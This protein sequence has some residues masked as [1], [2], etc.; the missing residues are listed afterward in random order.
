M[1]PSEGKV[2][3]DVG[4]R[5]GQTPLS[6]AA[7]RGYTAVIKLLLDTGKVNVDLKAEHER[8][9]LLLAAEGWHTVVVKLLLDSKKGQRGFRKYVWINATIISRRA[10]IRGSG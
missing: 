7:Q 10:W 5:Y 4:D 9:P 8:T 1:L 3:S 6:L 2:N